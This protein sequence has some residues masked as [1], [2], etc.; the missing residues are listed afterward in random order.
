MVIGTTSRRRIGAAPAPGPPTWPPVRSRIR[1]R[2]AGRKCR[3]QTEPMTAARV[4][5]SRAVGNAVV[6][7]AAVVAKVRPVLL[8]VEAEGGAP[9]AVEADKVYPF[10]GLWHPEVDRGAAGL[11]GQ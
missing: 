5:R 7:C 6:P 11:A 10:I 1:P 9:S 3:R 8:G 2:P 4:P